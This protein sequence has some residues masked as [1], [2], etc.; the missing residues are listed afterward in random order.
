MEVYANTYMMLNIKFPIGAMKIFKSDVKQ[1]CS[2]NV[3]L[4]LP[5]IPM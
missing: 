2:R 4:N 1:K 5:N 3:H